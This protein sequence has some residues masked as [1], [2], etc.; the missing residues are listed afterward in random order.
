M[1]SPK[2]AKQSQKHAGETGERDYMPYAVSL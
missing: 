1:P 2:N